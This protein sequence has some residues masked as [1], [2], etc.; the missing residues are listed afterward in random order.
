MYRGVE[1]EK[2]H[3]MAER[4]RGLISSISVPFGKIRICPTVSIGATIAR[5]DDTLESLF[6]RAD[7]A[8]YEAKD[9][10]RNQVRIS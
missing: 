10:G 1:R 5:P 3:Q 4:L 8:L 2:L 9:S 6:K 7:E